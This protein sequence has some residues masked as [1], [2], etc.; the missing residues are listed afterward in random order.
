MKPSNLIKLTLAALSIILASCSEDKKNMTSKAEAPSISL[1]PYLLTDAPADPIDI[2]DMRK[3]ASSGDTVTFS[4]KA[5][6]KKQIFMKDR[7]IM[8]LGDPKK[9]ISCDLGTCKGCPT[10]WDACCDLPEDIQSAI[11]SVQ[12]VDTTGK[13]LQTGIK[14]LGGIKELSE[15]IITGIVAPGSNDK[16]MLINATG[17]FVKKSTTE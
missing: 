5:L 13:P 2:L 1:S 9:L 8:V 6:G 12:I 17:I 11:V 3:S 14:G 15:V 7:A 4:G 16:N 10:P